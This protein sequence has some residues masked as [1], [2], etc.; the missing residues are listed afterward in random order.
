M[1]KTPLFN[2]FKA[3]LFIAIRSLRILLKVIIVLFLNDELDNNIK[4]RSKWN[5]E[6]DEYAAEVTKHD[7]F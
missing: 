2:I 1:N 5:R 6:Y 3:I 7:D 4:K